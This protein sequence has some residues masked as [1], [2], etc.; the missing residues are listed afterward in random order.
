MTTA[1]GSNISLTGIMKEHDWE[2]FHFDIVERREKSAIDYVI[3]V[4]DN[5]VRSVRE[6]DV[7]NML[8]D[9]DTPYE[10]EHPEGKMYFKQIN[11]WGIFNHFYAYLTYLA[12]E[13]KVS[14]EERKEFDWNF[15][16]KLLRGLKAFRD[17]RAF[18]L[19]EDEK[20]ILLGFIGR[21]GNPP[22]Q[23]RNYSV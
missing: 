8:R 12:C 16:N 7:P 3:N 13:E 17:N 22:I 2:M 10:P 20:E 1:L 18:Q 21:L 15:A 9:E 5:C 14:G 4:V 11:N 19:R 23:P 6:E